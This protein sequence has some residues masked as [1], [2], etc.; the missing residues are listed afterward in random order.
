[1][2]AEDLCVQRGAYTETFVHRLNK[3]IYR[4]ADADKF[5][6]RWTS[7]PCKRGEVR[8]TLPHISHGAQGPSTGTR[9][10]ILPWFVGLQNDMSTLEIAEAGT[11]EHMRDAH[12]GLTAGPNLTLDSFISSPQASSACGPPASTAVD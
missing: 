1:V 2:R 9:R 8:I 3:Q 11:W 5:G 4:E 12:I 10:T 7:V 6:I